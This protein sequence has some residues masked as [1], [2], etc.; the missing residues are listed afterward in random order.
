MVKST[1]IVSLLLSLFLVAGLLAGCGGAASSQSGSAPAAESTGAS[2]A[3]GGE[4]GATGNEE[5]SGTV[6]AWT[7]YSGMLTTQ[8]DA[9]HKVYPN[10]DFEITECASGNDCATKLITAVAAG[11][12]LPDLIFYESNDRY[13]VISLDI[14]ENLE[15]EPY[16]LDRNLL[17]DYV[18]PLNSNDKGEIVGMETTVCPTGL[19]YQVDLAEEYFGTSDPAELEALLGDWDALLEAGKKMKAENPDM[20]LFSN[21]GDVVNL[22]INQDTTS[23]DDNGS[24]NMEPMK[25]TVATLLA[26]K[27]AGLVDNFTQWTTGWYGSFTSK[28]YMFFTCPNWSPAYTVEESDP[29]AEIQWG[30]IVPPGGG[31]SFGGTSLGI[32]KNSDKKDLV[33]AYIQW[34]CLTQEGADGY[35]EF[36]GYFAPVKSVYEDEAFFSYHHPSFGEQDIGRKLYVDIM[37]NMD[38]RPISQFD[39]AVN[40]GMSSFM[41]L[42]DTGYQD[43][44]EED[45]LALLE[46]EINSN[47]G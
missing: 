40:A 7:W 39:A 36:V 38:S 20:F 5:L 11:T 45:A 23:Y 10:I 24:L 4:A 26:F 17:V 30:M 42:L 18:I 31:V 35:K 3:G 21:D 32:N 19:A 9:F 34:Q 2:G 47:I 12:D 13:S 6:T 8:L 33:W 14:L 44:T 46:Q 15:A 25:N 41:V 1:K 16:N 27:Q 22:L 28:N 29:D 43:M 37:P